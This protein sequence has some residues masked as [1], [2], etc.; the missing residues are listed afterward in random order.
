M[1]SDYT[2]VTG[3]QSVVTSTRGGRK[4]TGK[5][6]RGEGSA[7]G[8]AKVTADGR[9]GTGGLDE[10]GE[11]EPEADA[12]EG[13]VEEGGRVDR[14]AEKKKMAYVLST[15]LYYAHNGS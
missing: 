9:S 10:D 5:R 7:T 13:M 8:T 3:G 6:K 4:A 11:E 2:A 15:G 14:A 1:D 12:E